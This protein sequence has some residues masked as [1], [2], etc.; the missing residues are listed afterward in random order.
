MNHDV[1]LRGGARR[2]RTRAERLTTPTPPE[3][4]RVNVNVPNSSK[5]C[6]KIFLRRINRGSIG[7]KYLLSLLMKFAQT[8]NSITACVVL[9]SRRK[10]Y[11]CT[12]QQLPHL[13]PIVISPVGNELYAFVIMIVH[14][15]ANLNGWRFGSCG[16][17]RVCYM[18]MRMY[19]QENSYA[20]IY[21]YIRIHNY[22][23]KLTWISKYLSTFEILK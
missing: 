16:N 15:Y 14:V 12:Q 11:C 23:E 5:I 21:V 19:M 8:K 7:R 1:G 18:C 4:P 13:L 10:Q 20:H 2:W 22:R 9:T 3:N 6:W 17:E